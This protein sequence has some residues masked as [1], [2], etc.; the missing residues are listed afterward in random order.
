MRVELKMESREDIKG[1]LIGRTLHRRTKNR[2]SKLW[3]NWLFD[4]V[5][6]SVWRSIASTKT[7]SSGSAR[8]FALLHGFSMIFVES[9]TLSTNIGT[10][11][12][13]CALLSL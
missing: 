11:G 1:W 9:S 7:E 12:H 13:W 2:R 10:A 8:R 6:R 4:S 5:V 3:R